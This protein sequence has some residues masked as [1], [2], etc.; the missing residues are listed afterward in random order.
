MTFP[1]SVLVAHTD[2][3]H[4]EIG[5]LERAA[6]DYARLTRGLLQ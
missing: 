3:E 2:E 4:V 6:S 1:G 5:D